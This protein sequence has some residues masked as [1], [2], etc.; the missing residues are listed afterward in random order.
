[1]PDTAT[2]RDAFDHYQRGHLEQARQACEVLL[3]SEPKNFNALNILGAVQLQQADYSE[4]LTSLEKAVALKPDNL[5]ALTNLGSCLDTLH[6]YADAR[7]CYEQALELDRDYAPALA[8]LGNSLSREGNH[9]SALARYQRAIAHT[10]E[11]PVLRNNCGTALART[12]RFREALEEFRRALEL[13]PDYVS[14]LANQASALSNLKRFPAAAESYDRLLLLEPENAR[15][16]SKGFL[17]RR[18]VCDWRDFEQNAEAVLATAAA[19]PPF[20]LLSLTDSGA[21][22]L[23]AARAYSRQY[24]GLPALACRPL[25]D[26]GEKIRIAYLSA[27]FREHPVSYLMAGVFERHNRQRFE[28]TGANLS[29]PDK[30]CMGQRLAAAF[31][32]WLD[33]SGLTDAEA[34]RLLNERGI[35][36]AVDLSGYTRGNRAGILARR[37]APVQISYLGYPGT[38][39]AEFIDYVIADDYLVP[40]HCEQH[41]SESIIRLPGGFQAVDDRKRELPPTPTRATAGLPENAWV[42]CCFNAGYKISPGVFNTWMNIL[43]QVPNSVMW[44]L[45]RD[46]STRE[47]LQREAEARG[48]T[49]K[50]LVFAGELDYSSHLSRLPLADL[51]LDTFPFNGGTTASDALRMGLPLLT[52]SGGSFASRMAGS[53]LTSLGLP[54]LITTDLADY[55]TRAVEL[56]SG[57]AEWL[58]LRRHLRHQLSSARL[59]D[60]TAFCRANEAA[61]EKVWEHHK[62]GAPP[63]SF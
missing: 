59:F 57:D 43:K 30:G 20:N 39:G 55:Q 12:G 34:A 41:Y 18:H 6:H 62:S 63:R 32:N 15:A 48:I 11:D 45:A 7:R 37:P 24:E 50:R 22:Q 25:R 53:L 44:L 17:A 47:N 19:I 51:F 1:M 42:F 14:A 40:G 52:T 5:Q 21:V 26:S 10:P 2:I 35:D 27:D 16:L 3:A 49:R 54:E 56:A 29:P 13:D 33:L 58:R 38:T 8:K 61:L 46:K 31:D 4:A 36:I 23:A 60:T 28:L 9:A